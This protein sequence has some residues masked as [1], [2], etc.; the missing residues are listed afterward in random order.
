MQYT[1]CR[2]LRLRTLLRTHGPLCTWYEGETPTRLLHERRLIFTDSCG[3][4]DALLPHG[5]QHTS[6]TG[7]NFYYKI[8]STFE[9]WQFHVLDINGTCILQRS[10]KVL[11]GAIDRGFLPCRRAR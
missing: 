9:Q 6:L 5:M 2:K 1:D 8:F 11:R 7:S 4:D 10:L 3:D